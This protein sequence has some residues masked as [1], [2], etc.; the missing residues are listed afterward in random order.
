MLLTDSK[1]VEAFAQFSNAVNSKKEPDA[2]IYSD[3]ILYL[4]KILD[5]NVVNNIQ[6]LTE[7]TNEELNNDTSIVLDFIN[8]LPGNHG[9]KQIAPSDLIYRYDSLGKLHVALYDSL[10]VEYHKKHG[11]IEVSNANEDDSSF[12][13]IMITV[14][15]Q[16][17][18]VFLLSSRLEN[19]ER[20]VTLVYQMKPENNSSLMWPNY[21]AVGM[22]SVG[23]MY[24][25][26]TSYD[27]NY[28]REKFAAVLTKTRLTYDAIINL[29]EV[30]LDVAKQIQTEHDKWL[31]DE[32]STIN[33]SDFI[34]T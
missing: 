24:Y 2:I 31:V 8:S 16:T 17:M 20:F 30:A 26:T 28:N 9:D 11:I 13:S 25:K 32:L 15:K 34:I 29:R 4:R 33:S 5:N 19:Q 1:F 3:L 18:C 7:K 14:S 21:V 6:G 27:L 23:A 12:S 22:N 10:G